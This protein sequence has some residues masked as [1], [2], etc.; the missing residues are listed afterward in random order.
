MKQFKFLSLLF[1][2]LLS[3]AT[4]VVACGDDDDDSN[5]SVDTGLVGAW[6]HEKGYEILILNADG[7]GYWAS[8][9]HLDELDDE[10]FIWSASDGIL[11]IKSTVVDVDYSYYEEEIDKYRYMLSGDKL[12]LTYVG[13]KDDGAQEVYTRVNLDDLKKK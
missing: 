8:P 13:G 10:D 3:A 12:T 4:F 6:L 1:V 2:A 5:G 11:T 9:R 7:K